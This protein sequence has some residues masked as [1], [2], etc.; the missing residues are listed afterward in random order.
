MIL[1]LLGLGAATLII[2]FLRFALLQG[3]QIKLC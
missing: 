1:G 2:A 3:Y